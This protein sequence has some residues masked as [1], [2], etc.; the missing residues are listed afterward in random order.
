MSRTWLDSPLRNAKRW[1]SFFIQPIVR[2]WLPI[3]AVGLC[4]TSLGAGQVP[5]NTP[6]KPVDFNRDIRPI[7]SDNCFKCHGPEEEGRQGN[8]RLDSKENVF[9]DHGGYRIIVPGSSATSRLY[10]RISSKERRMPPASS[11]RSLT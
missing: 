10:Q 5:R 4:L 3:A 9:A 7:L 1:R 8:L 6:E 11:G 2:R